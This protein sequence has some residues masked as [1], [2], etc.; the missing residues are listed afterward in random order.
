M[1]E[2]TLESKV[3]L[4]QA[5]KIMFDYLE[6]YYDRTGQPSEIGGLLGQLALWNTINGKEPMD[7]AVFPDWLKSASRVLK[8][9]EAGGYPNIEIKLI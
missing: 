4:R 6:G 7:G 8:D 9:E 1:N 2:I 3:T 5:Y